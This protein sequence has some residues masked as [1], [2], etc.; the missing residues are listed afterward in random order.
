MNDKKIKKL[1][2][3]AKTEAAPK[4]PFVFSQTVVA[5]IHREDRE[6]TAVSL[7]DL[8]NQ[9]FPKVAVASL[10]VIGVC[11]ASDLLMAEKGSSLSTDVVEVTEQ[12]LF[13]AN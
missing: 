7:F 5:S 13:A 11:F 12:W 3:A 4:P 10:I 6:S 1:F 8:L 2:H 9:L